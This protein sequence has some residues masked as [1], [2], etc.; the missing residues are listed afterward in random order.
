MRDLIFRGYRSHGSGMIRGKQIAKAIGGKWNPRTC[1]KDDCFIY[2][3]TVPK[4]S[5]IP[6]RCFIDIVDYRKAIYWLR[7]HPDVPCIVIS[8]LADLYLSKKIPNQRIIIPQQHCNDEQ[9]TRPD[10]PVKTVGYIGSPSAFQLDFEEVKKRL[11][12][13]GLDFIW[14]CKK[15]INKNFVVYFYRNIDIQVVFRQYARWD[16][17]KSLKDALKLVNAGSYGIP[18]VCYPE[19]GY[20]DECKGAYV[21]INNIDE[22]VAECERLAK[23]KIWYQQISKNIKKISDKHHIS[24]ILPLYRNI[25]LN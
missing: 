6:K 22:M 10:R 8:K 20:D 1:D 3:K 15:L 11:A 25:W 4:D 16:L 2:V 13:V 23:N 17:T 24:K 12:E 5:F 18:T 14:I 19:Q 21:P 9:E 7:L